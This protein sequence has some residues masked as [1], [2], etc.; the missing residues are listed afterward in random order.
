MKVVPVCPGSA[1]ANCYLLVH[2]THALV[3]D[4]CVSVSAI[5]R[6]AKA[7]HATLEGILLTHGH[8][9]HMLS[10]DE[11]RA[12]LPAVPV[13]IHRDDA[14]NLANGKKNAFAEFFG[15]DRAWKAA[16]RLLTDG[17][18]LP[19]GDAFLTVLHTPGHTKG[20]CCYLASDGSFLLSG[21]TMFAAG[22]GRYDLYGGD[23]K[24]LAASL[25]RISTLPMT[26]MLAP[27]HGKSTTLERAWRA[28]GNSI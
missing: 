1:M 23:E 3:V 8:F 18:T 13:Y 27:G 5:L 4:P 6:A 15:Q 19:L 9:D 25:Q 17:D 24:A 16:D 10:L 14:E 28:L 26:L 12:A 11:L 22:Y 2:N 21:D 7:E 20:S